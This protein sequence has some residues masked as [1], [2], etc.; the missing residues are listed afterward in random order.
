MS[1]QNVILKIRVI[2]KRTTAG[3]AVGLF[4][5]FV[6]LFPNVI[7]KDNQ[8]VILYIIEVVGATG[9]VDW[10]VKDRKVIKA[11]FKKIFTRKKKEVRDENSK[12]VDG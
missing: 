1:T 9:I 10:A 2:P 3:V 12:P 11:W 8:N 5:A 6:L 7:S 4:G